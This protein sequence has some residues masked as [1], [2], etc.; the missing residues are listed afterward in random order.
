[1]TSKAVVAL[2][3]VS[4]WKRT[5]CA[6]DVGSPELRKTVEELRLEGIGDGFSKMA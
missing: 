3:L 5:V 1:M 4:A 6:V 2:T